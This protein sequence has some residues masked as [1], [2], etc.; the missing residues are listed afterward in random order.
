MI[1]AVR[2]HGIQKDCRREEHPLPSQARRGKRSCY[3]HPSPKSGNGAHSAKGSKVSSF[4]VGG[5]V[6]LY[7]CL[8]WYSGIDSAIDC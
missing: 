1:C 8:Y 4:Y 6:T 7:V 2:R 5:P 3:Q